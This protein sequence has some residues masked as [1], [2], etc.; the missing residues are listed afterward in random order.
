MP[1]TPDAPTRRPR[2]VRRR[3][4]E[5]RSTRPL[6]RRAVTAPATGLSFVDP[7]ERVDA[8]DQACLLRAERPAA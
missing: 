4:R 6:P 8:A 1:A 5:A 2:P 7:A 3:P